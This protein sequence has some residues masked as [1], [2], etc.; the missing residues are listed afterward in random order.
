MEDYDLSRGES[1]SSNG[2]PQLTRLSRE[3]FYIC[4]DIVT[5]RA[6]SILEWR[7]ILR[8]SLFVLERCWRMIGNL[9]NIMIFLVAGMTLSPVASSQIS[10]FPDTLKSEWRIETVDSTGLARWTSMAIDSNGYP[11]ISYWGLRYARWNG[12]AWE[13]DTP[14]PD[15]LVGKWSSIAVDSGDNP[16]ISYYGS[17]HLKYARKDG[18]SWSVEE[19]DAGAPDIYSSIALD[20]KDNP[21]VSYFDGS[22]RDLKYS[23]WN[24][25]AWEIEVVDSFGCVGEYS[26][27]ALDSKDNPHISYFDNTNDSLKYAKW[28]GS[29]WSLEVVN[30]YGGADTSIAVDSHDDPHI[31]FYNYLTGT[32]DDLAYAKRTGGVWE[33]ETVDSSRV[34]TWNSITIDSYNNP[35]ISYLNGSDFDNYVLNYAKKVGDSW[36]IETVDLDNAGMYTSIAVD[37]NDDP[38]ISYADRNGDLRYATKTTPAMERSLSLNIDPDTLNLN[39]RGRWITAYITTENAMAEDIDPSS[40]L[41][42]DVIAPAWWNIQNDTTLMVKFDR[43]AVQAILPVSNA[44][45]IKITGQWNDGEAFELHDVIRVIDVGGHM[46]SPPLVIRSMEGIYGTSVSGS[47]PERNLPGVPGLKILMDQR[48]TEVPAPIREERALILIPLVENE[49]AVSTLKYSHPVQRTLI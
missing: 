40:L 37:K 12:S 15:A 29:G 9:T 17:G 39:S 42:N 49:D 14:D 26:S 27:L 2:S 25:S 34:G 3:R 28:N 7:G 16:H 41:L 11:H 24:G 18:D 30:L 38:H 8:R 21:H 31:S 46:E 4:N 33:V 1:H 43:V 22:N 6:S 10:E 47:F 35:H 5:S 32:R 45:D 19:V 13:I 44:V 36:N 20:S 23:K 48:V